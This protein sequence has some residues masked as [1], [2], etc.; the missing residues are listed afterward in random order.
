MRYNGAMAGR[1]PQQ[2]IDE[3]MSRTDIVE[4]INE[5]VPLKKAGREFTACCPFHE[6]KTP[7]FTVSPA[8][9]FFHCFGC[10][11]HGTAL[12]FLMDYEHMEFIDALQELAERANMPMP[13]D[14]FPVH[15]QQ[16]DSPS[17]YPLLEE[18]AAWFHQQ[19]H[20]HPKAPSAIDY[21][22]QRA[23]TGETAAAFEIGFAPPGWDNL[24][25]TLGKNSEQINL[26]S[27]AGLITEKERGKHY[28]RFRNRIIFPIRDMRG[29]VVGFGGRALG[30]TPPK[31]LNSPE[32][33]VF[34]KGLELYGLYQARKAVRKLERIVIVEGYMDVVSLAQ[35]GIGYTVAAMGTATTQE[36]LRRLFRIVPEIVFCFDGDRAGREAAVRAMEIAIPEIRGGHQISF[37]FLPEGEDPDSQIQKEGRNRFETRIAESVTL[38][39]FFFDHLMTQTDIST[40]EGRA[41]LVELARP[42]LLRMRPG[43]LREMMVARLRELSRLE[44]VKLGADNRKATHGKATGKKQ[45]FTGNRAKNTP[46]PLR[47]MM[48][49]LLQYPGLAPLAENPRR[50]R[51]IGGAGANLLTEILELLQANPELN[52]G[53][54]LER[55]RDR[56]EGHYLAKLAQWKP[57]FDDRTG[58]EA[59]FKGALRRLEQRIEELRAEEL[60]VKADTE[61]LS[62]EEKEELQRLLKGHKQ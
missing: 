37:L 4:L 48:A 25:R 50:F 27:K 15:D 14:S 19:L 30:D 58:L 1:I 3:L 29:R 7:S 61:A 36:H 41:R 40:I 5:F 24:L 52:A 45:L 49:L 55:W 60:L 38:S 47:L 53:A 44:T 39:T 16:Q 22:K 26:L 12:G 42:H 28:D 35:H 11:A 57:P 31:Y 23:L 33:P 17:L 2:F 51:K 46:S 56:S 13:A 8:K 21:L 62:Q 20:H 34:H 6:E 32:T 43:V 9:Q 54:I 59:E 18:A 10:G